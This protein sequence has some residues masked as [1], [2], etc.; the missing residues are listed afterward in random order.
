MADRLESFDP[1]ESAAIAREELSSLLFAGVTMSED[2][3][4][5]VS[6]REGLERQELATHQRL[7]QML[8]LIIS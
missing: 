4:D 2:R 6:E 8:L 5:A 3:P 7:T 1:M